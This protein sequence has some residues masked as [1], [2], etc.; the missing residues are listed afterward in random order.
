MSMKNKLLGGVVLLMAALS[1][2]EV[3]A[4]SCAVPPT[5]QQMGYT[6]KKADCGE[7]LAL[8]CP[9]ALSDDNQV[10]CSNNNTAGENSDDEI[11]IGDIVYGDGTISNKAAV[12]KIPIGIVFDVQN[13]LAVALTDIGKDGNPVKND[14]PITDPSMQTRMPWGC[15]DCDVPGLEN[16]LLIYGTESSIMEDR[17]CGADG[18]KNTTAILSSNCSGTAYAA[19]ACNKYEPKGCTQDFCKKTK[20]FLPSIRELAN[21]KDA[22]EQIKIT[23]SFFNS[24]IVYAE[25]MDSGQ[26]TFWS[27]TEG[28]YSNTQDNV[29]AWYV[30]FHNPSNS[31]YFGAANSKEFS[32]RVRPVVKF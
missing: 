24:S 17:N 29:F 32:H 2:N 3:Q 26:E 20:W 21:L 13:R 23:M 1:L 15:G 8:R 12:N 31:E 10:Y 30:Y 14:I 25:A 27:S 11:A 5:C 28:R 16:C 7:N 22:H 6:M 9:F 18:R 4:T 19:V